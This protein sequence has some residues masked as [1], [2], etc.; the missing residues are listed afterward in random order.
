[1]Q[2]YRLFL[3][4]QAENLLLLSGEMNAFNKLKFYYKWQVLMNNSIIYTED[5]SIFINCEIYVSFDQTY[6]IL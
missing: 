1:M 2:S 5:N 4:I 3:N 6:K